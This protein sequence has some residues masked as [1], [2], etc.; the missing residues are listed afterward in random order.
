MDIE[1]PG[2]NGF[3]TAEKVTSLYYFKFLL[4][5]DFKNL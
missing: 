2:L 5:K 4:N 1:M 3:E